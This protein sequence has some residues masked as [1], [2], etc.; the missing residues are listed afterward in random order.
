ME[1]EGTGKFG[2][3]GM[4]VTNQVDVTDKILSV[5][6]EIRDARKNNKIWC[7]GCFAELPTTLMKDFSC[8]VCP[9]KEFLTARPF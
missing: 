6:K 1:L 5:P 7:K 3:N 9:S 8:P 2:S 4:R